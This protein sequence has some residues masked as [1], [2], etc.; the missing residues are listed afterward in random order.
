MDLIYTNTTRV[1]IGVLSAYAL[2]L[3]F[4]ADEAENDFEMTVGMSE[5][6]I[7]YGAV[8]YI[9]GTEYGGIVDAKRSCTADE[10]IVYIGRTWHGVL[11]SK[12]IQPDPGEDYLVVSGDANQVLGMLID[13]LGLSGLFTAV[14]SQSGIA[15][16][17]YQFPRYCKGYDGIR[18]MLAANG[19][20]IKISWENRS[21]YLSA[22]PIVDYTKSPVDND[23]TI[24]TVEQHEKKVNHMICLGRG[25]LA[26]REVI[27]LYVDQFG[28]IGDVQYYTGLD[29]IIN[30]YENTDAESTE[31]LRNGG[32]ERIKELREIDTAEFS[33]PEGNDSMYDIGDVIGATDLK[34]GISVSAAVS[35]KIV[36]INNGTISTEY[37][38]GS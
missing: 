21:V 6:A 5:A 4:G 24:V 27:H 9:E 20:K 25:E 17:K 7:P 22:V 2:D 19:A 33:F 29:E 23:T 15:V 3:S 10:N 14:E 1:D 16:S 13:R 34:T 28:R 8:V 26:E 18:A 35:Q 12:V 32:I 30:I 37:S 31:D 36:R 11:N 38:T